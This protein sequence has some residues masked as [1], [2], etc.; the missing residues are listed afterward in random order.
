MEK[1]KFKLIFNPFRLCVLCIT[2]AFTI[3]LFTYYTSNKYNTILS[4]IYENF[5]NRNY[6]VAYNL[7]TNN[8]NKLPFHKNSI[9]S[10]LTNYFSKIVKDICSNLENEKMSEKDS[11]DILVQI[12]KFNLLGTTLDKLILTLDENAKVSN[13]TL[14]AMGI[15][16][17]NQKDYIKSFKYFDSISSNDESNYAEASK[18]KEK[19]K[20]DYKDSLLKEADTLVANKY[21]T[22]AIELLSN[23]N[24][25]IISEDDAD[26]ANKINFITMAKDEYL[27]NQHLE[28]AQYTS[29]AVLDTITTDNV[30]SLHIESK[31]PYLLYVN[32][33]NQETSVYKGELNNWNLVKTISCSTGIEGEETPKGVYS[34]LNRGDW[35]FSEDYKQGG[36]YWIQFMGDYLFHSV[37]FDEDQKTI[38]D[39]T[40]GKPASHGC[41]RLPLDESKWLYD[42]IPNDTKLIIN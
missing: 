26:I 13:N 1:S 42:N 27:A 4:S 20:K 8:I 40:L 29:N 41:I 35:F 19:I 21:Y 32:I 23:F 2:I 14:L 38:L 31:T 24:V 5:N 28:D 34:I 16:Y 33:A 3:F 36:K 10:D 17:Y 30:N 7:Y 25:S 22:K 11:L 37:P 18:Y 6:E 39:Y 12:Q 15:D 9:N